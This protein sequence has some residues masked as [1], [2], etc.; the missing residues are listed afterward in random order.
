MLIAT[1]STEEVVRLAVGGGGLRVEAGRR[2]TEELVR[3][4]RA[5]R[6]QGGQVTFFGMQPRP[7]R[8][9]L[10]IVEAGGLW[11]GRIASVGP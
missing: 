9:L 11:Q 10:Q 4:A 7:L 5:A 1:G 2:P 6:S 3:I 8:E